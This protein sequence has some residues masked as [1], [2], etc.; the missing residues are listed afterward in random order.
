MKETIYKYLERHYKNPN[1]L[2]FLVSLLFMLVIPPLAPLIE[3]G[4]ILFNIT[5]GLVLFMGAFYTSTDSREFAVF[6]LVGGIVYVL[7]LNE[8]TTVY[9][10]LLNAG[11]TFL[12]FSLI[13]LKLVRY[14]LYSDDIDINEIY[15][16]V[17]GYLIL[18]IVAA[19]LFYLIEQT[20]GNAFHLPADYSFYDFIYFSFITLTSVGYG[21][22]S[23]I[24]PFAKAITIIISI[25]GQLYLTILIAIIIGKYLASKVK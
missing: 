13:F 12:F 25:F 11:L 7:F 3:N 24:H 1:Y 15:A 17:S 19:P 16:C 21:D 22:I 6:L 9:Y 5:Y 14:I 23:P 20:L 4:A 10:S 18:G 2:Y 8:Q